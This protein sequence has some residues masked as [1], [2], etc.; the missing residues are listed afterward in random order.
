MDACPSRACSS[1]AKPAPRASASA[2][3]CARCPTSSSKSLP[4]E[5]R[6]DPAA[7]R[8]M[9]AEVDL[10]IL[11]LPDDA[12]REAAALADGL[13]NAAPKLLDASTAHRVHPDWA[14][15]FPEMQPGQA[16]RIASARKVANPRLLSHRRDRPDPPAGRCRDHPVPTIRSRINAVSGYSGGGRSM[17]EEH[18]P[19]GRSSLRTLCARA[20]AQA[21][22]RDP[23]A[24]AACPAGR[25]SCRRSAT[26][27][28][29]CWSPCRCISTRCTARPPAPICKRCWR[30]AIAAAIMS[31]SL[32][33]RPIG[34][35]EPESAERDQPAG[36][37]LSMPTRSIGRRCW[38][39]GST[40]SARARPAR[41][42]RTF[43]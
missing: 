25:S 29:A 9:M 27:A 24:I 38:S 34:K 36:T 3:A 28:R 31:A 7:R 33:R 37:R 42:C 15:G 26:T 11:C 41:R 40:I 13:G 21:P 39:R 30:R 17:I 20:R 8:D 1:M 32:P 6:R 22:A 18:E 43:A 2:T 19:A 5:H 16:E 23:D 14:Y 35:L 4:A 12:A 10:V